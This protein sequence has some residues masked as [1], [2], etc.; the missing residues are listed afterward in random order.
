MKNRK[1]VY[2]ELTWFFGGVTGGI[3]ISLVLYDIIKVDITPGVMAAGVI[4]TL[5]AMYVIR[6]T[7]WVFKQGM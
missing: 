2:R 3:F 1:G 4:A 7:L 5:L 6:M